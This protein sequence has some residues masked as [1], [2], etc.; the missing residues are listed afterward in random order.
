MEKVIWSLPTSVDVNGTEYGIRSDYRAVLDILT[1]LTDNELDDHLKA[2]AA[3]E[4]FY[5]GS[6]K[7]LQETIRR[8]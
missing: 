8:P 4:I 5:P 1:A 2:E 7:C 3:L 6:T